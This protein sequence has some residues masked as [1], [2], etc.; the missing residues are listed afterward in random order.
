MAQT[1]KYKALERLRKALDEIAGLKGLSWRSPEFE[2]W[3]RDTR[4]AITNT[5]IGKPEHIKDFE[6]IRYISLSIS[7]S[8]SADQEA[9]TQGLESAGAVLESMIHEVTEY[10]EEEIESSQSSESRESKQIKTKEVFVVHG[11]DE[12]AREKVARFLE[13]LDLTPIVLHE[14]PNEGRTVIEKFED[15]THVGFAVVLLT[16]DDV[17]RLQDDVNDFRPRARQNVIFEFGYFVGKLGR[18]YV[19]ALVQGALERPSDYDGVLYIPLDDSDG[20]K[21]RLVQELKNAGYNVDANRVF[22]T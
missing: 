6:A 17:G 8:S 2:K 21:I 9:Y 12:G 1:D 13:R 18:E 22:A 15:Y 16:P 3:Q 11:R 10:W 20:W 7:S 5:F 19:C 14:Q 4:I